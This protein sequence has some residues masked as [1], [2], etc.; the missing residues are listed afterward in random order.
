MYGLFAHANNPEAICRDCR[1]L[2]TIQAGGRKVYKCAVYGETSSDA[3]DWRI[4]WLAC[5]M[6][7]KAYTGKP[8]IETA[9]RRRAEPDPQIDGQLSLF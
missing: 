2:K 5:G 4:G 6:Y 8:V 3:T 1:H 9:G 7:G